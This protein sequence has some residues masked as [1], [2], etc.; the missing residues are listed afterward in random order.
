MDRR[1]ATLEHRLRRAIVGEIRPTIRQQQEAAAKP[2]PREVP[3]FMLQWNNLDVWHTEAGTYH[4]ITMEDGHL[5]QTV[6]WCVRNAPALHA[7]AGSPGNSLLVPA[8]AAAQW[9]AAQPIF[10][11]LV[12]ESIARN[13]TYPS[14]VF[15]FFKAYLLDSEEALEDYQPWQDPAK[16][17]QLEETK[18][19]ADLPLQP[20]EWDLGKPL[21]SIEIDDE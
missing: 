5:W 21:R 14:D 16:A 7:D 13:F 15:T 20:P 3:K 12:R 4:V 6:I 2:Q 10:R 11:K 8:L 17:S 18:S 19:L 1:E 9:L